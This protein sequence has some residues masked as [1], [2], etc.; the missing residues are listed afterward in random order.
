MSGARIVLSGGGTGGHVYPALSVGEQLMQDPDVE[1]ILYIGAAD[2]LEER[3][4]KELGLEFVGLTV[5]GM[6]RKMSP[7]LIGWS[8]QIIKATIDAQRIYKEFRP[9]AVLGTGGYA[10]APALAAAMTSGIPYAVHE[11]DAHPGLVNKVF[12]RWASLVSCGMEGAKQRLSHRPGKL[13][14][15]GNPI[16]ASFVNPPSRLEA[17]RALRLATDKLTLVVTGGSQGARAINEAVMGILPSLLDDK[18]EIQIVHQCGDKNIDD[19]KASLPT[20]ILNHPR[21]YL[22]PYFSDLS[23]AYAC[24]DLVVCRAGAMTIAELAVCGVPAVFIPY[25]FAAQDHQMHNARALEELNAAIVISQKELTS[26]LLLQNIKRLFQ[27]KTEL[28]AMKSHMKK[29]GK[30]DAARNLANQLKL[31]S[32]EFGARGAKNDTSGEQESSG[33][34]SRSRRRN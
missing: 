17:C 26:H 7:A 33:L 8:T 3:V 27:D 28:E 29:Q 23:V 22:K 9:T 30:P 18:M 32:R 24:A 5:T 10:S 16:R 14:I 6:P 1:A 25:P 2:H 13:K 31:L 20:D 4:S 12:A 19:I 34:K 11:P 21:Y 15:Y